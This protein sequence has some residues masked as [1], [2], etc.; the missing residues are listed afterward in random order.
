MVIVPHKSNDIEIGNTTERESD[1]A[2][3]SP[4]PQAAH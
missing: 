3:S 1:P 2:P 4:D